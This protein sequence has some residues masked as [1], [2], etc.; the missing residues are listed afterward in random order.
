MMQ[1]AT[2]IAQTGLYENPEPWTYVTMGYALCI[3]GI[4]AYTVILMVRGR[5]LARQVPPGERRWIT[6]ARREDES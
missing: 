1:L 2:L 3:L 4:L 5:R 6:S